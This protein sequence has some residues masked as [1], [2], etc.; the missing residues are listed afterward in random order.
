MK[1][2]IGDKIV[3]TL[4]NMAITYHGIITEEYEGLPFAFWV[5][6][7]SIMLNELTPIYEHE[8]LFKIKDPNDIMKEIV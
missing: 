3:F 4:S 7:P 6:C 5:S 1:Y 2:K 8:I